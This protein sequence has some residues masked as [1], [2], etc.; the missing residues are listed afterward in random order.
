M[1]RDEQAFGEVQALVVGFFISLD[2]F[3]DDRALA[4]LAEDV[5]WVRAS[6]TL[7]GHAAVRGV[8][9]DRPRDRR[10]RH[11]VNNLDV[12]FTAPDAATARCDILVFQGPA[13]SGGGPVAIAGPD[14]IIT[15]E[16]QLILVDGAWRIRRK[17][18]SVVFR[19]ATSGTLAEGR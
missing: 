19:V 4:C 7:K 2:E 8:L 3:D 10:T 16:D 15:N 14:S 5:E 18:P 12:R 11:L 6:G 1:P 17:Q 9:T 13:G